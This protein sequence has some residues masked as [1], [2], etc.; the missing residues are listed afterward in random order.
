MPKNEDA[1]E[2]LTCRVTILEESFAGVIMEVGGLGDVPP[3]KPDTK[4]E[5]EVAKDEDG[6]ILMVVEQALTEGQKDTLHLAMR[7]FKGGDFSGP[8]FN[9]Y[10][11]GEDI[12]L[13]RT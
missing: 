11:Q 5:V 13:E 7:L 2:A 8:G 3:S 4:I 12:V 9:V 1:I 10:L 6:D